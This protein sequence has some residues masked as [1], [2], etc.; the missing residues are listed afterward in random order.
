MAKT[1]LNFGGLSMLKAFVTDN[2]TWYTNQDGVI[3]V[4]DDQD[5]PELGDIARIG[6]D[7][8]EFK[9]RRDATF[10]LCKL[11]EDAFDFHNP[12]GDSTY[13]EYLD[14]YMKGHE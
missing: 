3:T 9:V 6:S 14:E 10:G 2:G 4:L 13:M 7:W 12:A 8:Y 5:K 1:V 11:S